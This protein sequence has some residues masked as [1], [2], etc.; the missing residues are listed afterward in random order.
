MRLIPD[1]KLLEQFRATLVRQDLSPATVK[2]YLH[3][4][5]ILQD[6]LDWVHGTQAVSLQEV[7]TI[8]LIAFRKCLIQ[9]KGQRPATVNRRVQALRT[10]FGWLRDQGLVEQSP[11]ERLRFMRRNTRRRPRGLRRREVLALLHAAG[12]SPHGTA[13]R[14]MALIQ[15]LLQTGLRAGEV[16]AL[17]IEDL[18]LGARSGSVRVRAGKG[19]KARDVPL[20]RSARRSLSDYLE[21]RE[22]TG[23]DL[24]GADPVF[25]SIRK[26]PLSTRGLQNAI[27]VLAERAGINRLP[28][29]AHALRHT[30]AITYLKS[31][32]G[33]LVD[34]SHLLGH[35]SLDTTAIYTQPSEEDLSQDLE[36]ALRRVG[37]TVPVGL[38]GTVVPGRDGLRPPGL[39]RSLERV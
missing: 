34:L 9:D 12:S 33:K 20:N 31:H 10:F 15:L 7:R 29:S 11:A 19:M 35:H 14:N 38:P 28:V 2:A 5:K 13:L 24:S 22:A 17:R 27:Y 30:F 1:R 25:V 21:D 32:P 6:W 23:D 8:D 3:D 36:P 4:L 39:A 26:R 16:T 37:R 18:T